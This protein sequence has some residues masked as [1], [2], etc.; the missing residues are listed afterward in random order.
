MGFLN[1]WKAMVQS[2]NT[3]GIYWDNQLLYMDYGKYGIYW[4]IILWVMN[5]WKVWDIMTVNHNIVK[6]SK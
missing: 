1:F 6:S 4:D 5:F 2:H 3:T